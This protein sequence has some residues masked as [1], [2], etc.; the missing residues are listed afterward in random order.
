MEKRIGYGNKHLKHVVSKFGY[1]NTSAI[2]ELVDNAKDANAINTNISY[3]SKLKELVIRDDGQGMDLE[4]FDKYFMGISTKENSAYSKNS[5]GENGV[6]A[7][8][9]ILNLIRDK[10]EI[11]VLTNDGQNKTVK[12]T[13]VINKNDDSDIHIYK[14][15][16]IDTHQ[17]LKG[18]II[19]ITNVHLTKGDL[20]QLTN[21]LG[22]YYYP[23]IKNGKFNLSLNGKPFNLQDPL[24]RNV[25]LINDTLYS[26]ILTITYN[27]K[28]YDVIVNGV[29]V[30]NDNIIDDDYILDFDRVKNRGVLKEGDEEGLAASKRAGLYIIFGGRYIS[31]GD[32]IDLLGLTHHCQYNSIRLEFEIP[33]ELSELFGVS[34]NKAMKMK[35]FVKKKNEEV[36]VGSREYILSNF[37]FK[38]KQLLNTFQKEYKNSSVTKKVKIEE[39]IIDKVAQKLGCKIELHP[40][41]NPLIPINRTIIN[42]DNKKKEK[43][44]L[45]TLNEE[46]SIAKIIEKKTK[47]EEIIA[48]FIKMQEVVDNIMSPTQRC[49]YQIQFEE[50]V[51]K[52]LK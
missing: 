48:L 42:K 22:V 33:K 15:D 21:Y 39:P 11:T 24:Y 5:I 4:T 23:T 1:T 20:K 32:N 52:I 47:T 35:P 14:S 2:N 3:N 37:T 12:G 27:G 40:F 45:L 19:T 51:R 44:S 26:T 16:Y 29:Y 28:E 49:E 17:D 43:L 36:L 30:F 9:A 18:T 46:H 50:N 7:K 13:W 8:Y 25:N 34:F 10:S 38:L 6:G 31:M 41:G